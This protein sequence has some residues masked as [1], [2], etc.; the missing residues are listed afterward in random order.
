MVSFAKIVN[1]R[2]PLTAILD[3]WPGSEFTL[4]LTSQNYSYTVPTLPL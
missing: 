4:E 2:K 3:V 1:D